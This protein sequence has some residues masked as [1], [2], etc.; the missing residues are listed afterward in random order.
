MAVI[1]ELPKTPSPLPQAPENKKDSIE[2]SEETVNDEKKAV[3]NVKGA[4]VISKPEPEERPKDIIEP[5]H[6]RPEKNQYPA[7]TERVSSKV[8]SSISEEQ[9]VIPGMEE[10]KPKAS[11]VIAL[12]KQ[13]K[14]KYVDK[15]QSNGALWIIG[16]RE[17]DP[18]VR[19][20]RKLGISFRY[21]EDGGKQTGYKPGWWAK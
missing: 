16:G 9:T 11:D 21:K 19:E 18:I 17:L 8:Q 12:L 14:V 3:P 4:P 6:S 13:S 1:R 5:F 7:K 15:R 2:P 10:K 20:C